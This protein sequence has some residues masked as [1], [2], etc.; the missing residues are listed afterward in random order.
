L[1]PILLDPWLIS[2]SADDDDTEVNAKTELL[3]RINE[4][5]NEYPLEV[6]AFLSPDEQETIWQD[7]HTYKFVQDRGRIASYMSAF[8][9]D[10]E[11]ECE[12]AVITDR[13][14]PSGELSPSWLKALSYI[15]DND[16]APRWRFPMLFTPQFRTS[17]WPS[18]EINY[19]PH[20][21][22]DIKTRNIVCI[23]EHQDHQYFMPDIDPWRLKCVGEPRPKGA[24]DQRRATCRRLPRPRKLPLNIPLSQLAER[25]LD[26]TDC[27]C[28]TNTHYYYLPPLSWQPT[29][30]E[31]LGW[32]NSAF[33]RDGIVLRAGGRR[34]SGYSDRNGHVWV[35]DDNEAY[36]WEVK[37]KD[38][39]RVAKVQFDGLK[40]RI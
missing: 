1:I 21:N 30:K 2:F 19:R 12:P 34:E 38:D 11:L 13:P 39:I 22:P 7:F 25:A 37:T 18:T 5:S 14:Y 28:G 4:L 33:D 27:T 8:C 6:I 40:K 20:G 24:V 35:W 31:R 26:I 3:S 10:Q 29:T 36:H 32:R 15:G 23:E 16:E 9:M 17:C